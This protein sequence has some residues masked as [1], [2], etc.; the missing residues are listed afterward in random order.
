[1]RAWRWAAVALAGAGMVG[2][3]APAAAEC[4]TVTFELHWWE[5]PD[6]YPLGQR[7]TCVTD[8]QWNKFQDIGWGADLDSEDQVLPYTP[9]GAWLQVWITG[10]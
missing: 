4:I 6:T 3:A 1:M 8:T 7:D 10:P 9:Q 5:E 2:G